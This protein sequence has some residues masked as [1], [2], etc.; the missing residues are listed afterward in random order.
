MSSL[1]DRKLNLDIKNVYFI[2]E[3]VLLTRFYLS[4][5]LVK[6]FGFI[7][8]FNRLSFPSNLLL[9]VQYDSFP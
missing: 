1:K 6:D 4:K 7:S 9:G 3:G 2:H 5:Y 8:L